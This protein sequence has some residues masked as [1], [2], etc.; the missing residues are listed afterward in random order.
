MVLSTRIQKKYAPL[1]VRSAQNFVRVRR[2]HRKK[3]PGRASGG[4][5][6][7]TRSRS[8][9]QLCQRHGSGDLLPVRAVIGPGQLLQGHILVSQQ[10]SH[11]LQTLPRLLQLIPPRGRRWTPPRYAGRRTPPGP[12]PATAPCPGAAP[13]PVCP[14]HSARSEPAVASSST[15]AARSLTAV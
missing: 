2:S 6:R 14:P 15:P 13:A 10:G 1:H 5:Q 9:L 8:M 11:L 12:G 7:R 3:R 4:S